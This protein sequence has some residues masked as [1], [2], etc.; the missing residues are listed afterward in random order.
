[1]IINYIFWAIMLWALYDCGFRKL[2]KQY[3]NNRAYVICHVGGY[4]F[5]FLGVSLAP[6]VIDT[7]GR[8]D[9]FTLLFF[10]LYGIGLLIVGISRVIYARLQHMEGGIS[11]DKLFIYRHQKLVI[12]CSL[13]SVLCAVQLG[14]MIYL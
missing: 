14:L 11:A 7:V 3:K 10:L 12:V 2:D 6:I 8:G 9:I 5:C 4:F 13:I 1:M